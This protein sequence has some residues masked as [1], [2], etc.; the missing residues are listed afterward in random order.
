MISESDLFISD[1]YEAVKESGGA[2]NLGSRF[3]IFAQ[4]KPVVVNISVH[5]GPDFRITFFGGGY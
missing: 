3:C 4:M 1:V 5:C 2:L